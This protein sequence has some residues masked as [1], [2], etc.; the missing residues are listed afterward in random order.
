VHLFSPTGSS[1][2][3]LLPADSSPI[4]TPV[5][6]AA[7]ATADSRSLIVRPAMAGV[8]EALAA[9]YRRCGPASRY[10]RFHAPLREL[11][12]EHLRAVTTPE[13]G[14]DALIV[15]HAADASRPLAL[16]SAHTG[17][18]G[19]VEVGLLVEDD[20][21][22]R[23]IGSLLLRSLLDR[24]RPRGAVALTA[25]V[26]GDQRWVLRM[27]QKHAGP[28]RCGPMSVTVQVTASLIDGPTER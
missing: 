11:P 10:Q 16:G 12:A 13:D 17:A 26:L 18:P 9:M 2:T 21:Q 24:A 4:G 8:R 25:T 27:L 1:V 5:I 15:A 22:R 6:A 20:W 3:G 19:V 23:G 28:L 14:V 7:P